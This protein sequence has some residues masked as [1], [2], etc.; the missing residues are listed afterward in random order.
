MN[1][2]GDQP[3]QSMRGHESGNYL[4]IAE[5]DDKATI[6]SDS[7]GCFQYSAFDTFDKWPF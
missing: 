4:T 1:K 6:Q 5:E 7:H 3:S 2:L